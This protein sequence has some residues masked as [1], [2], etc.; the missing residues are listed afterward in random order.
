MLFCHG[1]FPDNHLISMTAKQASVH[2]HQQRV[3]IMHGAGRLSRIKPGACRTS[4]DKSRPVGLALLFLHLSGNNLDYDNSDKSFDRYCS[5][6]CVGGD[7]GADGGAF[8]GGEVAQAAQ[9]E[10]KNV[11][12]ASRRSC[13]PVFADQ[14]W[15]Q[16]E[17]KGHHAMSAVGKNNLATIETVRPQVTTWGKDQPQPWSSRHRAALLAFLELLKSY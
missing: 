7:V 5:R 6:I 13:Q 3:E 4:A 9:E 16:G 1:Y 14:G 15:N 8:V 17:R 12:Q 10:I 11:F 2:K